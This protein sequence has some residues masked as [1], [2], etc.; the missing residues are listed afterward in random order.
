[1]GV[2][3]EKGRELLEREED[4]ERD[5]ERVKEELRKKPKGK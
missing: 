5:T 1:M 2:E 3:R 4:V